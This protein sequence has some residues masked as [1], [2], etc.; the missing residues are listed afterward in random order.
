MNAIV[1]AGGASYWLYRLRAGALRLYPPALARKMLKEEAA[2]APGPTGQGVA[3]ATSTAYGL[4]ARRAAA[5]AVSPP[6]FSPFGNPLSPI[7]F[8]IGVSLADSLNLI[9]PFNTQ[10]TC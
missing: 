5:N 3:T 7:S 6:Q 2:F 10:R 8:G 9:P 1:L 4:Q